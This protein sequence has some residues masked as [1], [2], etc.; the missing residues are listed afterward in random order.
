MKRVAGCVV[1]V[2]VVASLVVHGKQSRQ[3]PVALSPSSAGAVQHSAA[4]HWN[5]ALLEAI[6]NDYARP[7]VHAR[8]LFHT[9]IAMWDAWAAYDS[10]ARNYLHL[11]KLETE[12]LSA[13]RHEA[14][15]YASYRVIS[16]RFSNSPGAEDSLPSFDAKMAEFGYDIGFTDT[17]GDSPAAL[18]N[19]IAATVLA[20]GT[21]DGANEENDYAN[22]FYEPVNE[23]LLPVFPCN[24]SILDPNRWQPLALDFFVD[25]SGNPFPLGVPPFQSPEW[26]TVTP[27][28]LNPD[29]LTVHEI[30]GNQYW[31]YLDPGPPPMIGGV[32]EDEYRSG[33]EQVIEWSGLLDPADGVMIDI[34]PNARGNNRLG[35]NDGSGHALNPATGQPYLPEIVPA[36]DYYRV[37]AEF[38]ADGPDSETPPGHW[39]TIANYVSDH[40]LVVKRIAGVGPVVDDLEWDVK[41]YL[42]LAGSV[43]DSAVAAW[44]AKGGYDYIRPISAI[45][46]MADHGQSSDPA[47]VSYSPEG[48]RLKPG[49]IELVTAEST[50]AGQR[51]QHLV[52]LQG[53][54]IGKIAVWAW[55]G[56]DYIPDPETAVA[57]VGW[58][59]A[60]N[61]W[62]YQRPTFVTPP[63][64]GYVSGH[65]TFSRAAAEMMTLLT[66][67]AFFPGGLGEFFAPQNEFL[68]FEDGPSVDLTLQW[69]TYRDASDETSISRI[70]GGIHPTADDIP[71][72]IMGAQIGQDAFLKASRLYGPWPT[73][74]VDRI[75][76]AR[77]GRTDLVSVVDSCQIG[78][79]GPEDVLDVSQGVRITLRDARGRP[80]L[81]DFDSGDCRGRQGGVLRCLAR[82]GTNKLYFW[83]GAS[84][85]QSVN[86]R[87]TGRQDSRSSPESGPVQ[88]TITTGE[89]ERSGTWVE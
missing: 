79:F 56:P 68:V 35:T 47:L 17:V 32:G 43:H 51:H 23:P 48:I 28:A 84:A 36:G 75:D 59:L 82:G 67:D 73:V 41:M 66:G 46:Y 69:A 80:A 76:S 10:V 25:Q 5:E 78:V 6:R 4:R 49:V 31:L 12:D 33:F 44:G 13:A 53:R 24:P 2:L 3:R 70:Y 22:Q 15:S 19:R 55:R 81:F 38:W 52:G 87:L 77:R 61:W 63:F 40:P 21:S 62:P 54:N 18:G 64:A 1:L 29:D 60:E 8:N 72:R 85:Q 26:G 30:D 89:T 57:G 20:F 45:R 39:F 65:S 34:S 27:F 88:V 37:L 11:E 83:P 42:A 14:I 71:G 74:Q 16:A 50:A 9:S 7:T 58:I 86:F